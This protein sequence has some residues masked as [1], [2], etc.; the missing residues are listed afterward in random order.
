MKSDK[1]IIMIQKFKTNIKI[2]SIKEKK[3][4]KIKG[5]IK[6]KTCILASDVPE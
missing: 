3:K 1:L 2:K 5:Y 4:K 6:K